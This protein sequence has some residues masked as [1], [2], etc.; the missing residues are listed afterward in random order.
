MRD[1]VNP[2]LSRDRLLAW[3]GIQARQQAGNSA[4]FQSPDS[5]RS[6][7]LLPTESYRV[8]GCVCMFFRNESFSFSSCCISLGGSEKNRLKSL[9]AAVMLFNRLTWRR[10]TW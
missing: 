1:D 6:R 4:V 3:S 7:H 8:K 5:R 2:A 9:L 10:C